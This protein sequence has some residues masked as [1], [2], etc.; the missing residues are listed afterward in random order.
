MA[1]LEWALLGIVALCAVV[2][3]FSPVG[4]RHWPIVVFIALIAL[5]GFI[6]VA[7]GVDL[8]ECRRI[9]LDCLR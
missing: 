5:I 8:G 3:F 7:S 1:P 2:L 9:G 4:R 6:V